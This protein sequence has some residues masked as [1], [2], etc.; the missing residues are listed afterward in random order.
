MP[1]GHIRLSEAITQ[2]LNTRRAH[3]APDDREA[4]PVRDE[5]LPRL[6]RGHLRRELAASHVEN[7]FMAM[8]EEHVT[9][10]GRTRPP[11]TPST[12]NNY[13]ARIKSLTTYLQAR[14][15]TRHDLMR[16]IQ[17]QKVERRIR[18]QPSPSVMWQMLDAARDARD[19]ALL[20]TACNTGLACREPGGLAARAT[21][22]WTS[23]TLRVRVS[24]SHLEDDM[25]MTSDL[26][27]ELRDWLKVYREYQ[28]NKLDRIAQ[29][30]DYLFPARRTPTWK[31][32]TLEGGTR[33]HVSVPGGWDPLRPVRKPHVVAQ[34]ALQALGLPR[35]H[36]GIHTIRRG[37]AR[38]LF[39]SLVE[40]PGYD[41]ALRVVSSFLH[42]SNVSTTETYLGLTSERRTRDLHLR[43]R[44]LL[45]PRPGLDDARVVP[46]D[47][48]RT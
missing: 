15:Y 8:L 27:I 14:G 5:A 25:P 9:R 26:A 2:Y 30:T 38:A 7:Y 43:G 3:C 10:D 19:R 28:V 16:H 23:L 11:I 17:P 6:D 20:A 36:E 42:H 18:Q 40:G 24:K 33:S 32:I 13:F 12:W 46:L 22:T 4:G 1:A 44:S 31:W 41:G 47:S 45:G 48:H 37:A 35:V 21:W 34:D 29:A 39:D